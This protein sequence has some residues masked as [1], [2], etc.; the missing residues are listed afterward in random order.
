MITT[1]MACVNLLFTEEEFANGDA[2]GSNGYKQLD[3]IK[4]SFSSRSFAKNL[5]P[6]YFVAIRML[7]IVSTQNAEGK[8]EVQLE[9][10]RKTQVFSVINLLSCI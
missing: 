8:G 4:V 3:K 7:N 9:D 10:C 1:T 2:S 6:Q 5:I